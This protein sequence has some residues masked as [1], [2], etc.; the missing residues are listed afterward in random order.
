MNEYLL[1]ILIFL[2]GIATGFINTLAGSGSLISLPLLMFA[3]LPAPIANGTNR[4]GIVIQGIT[5][6]FTLRKKFPI[7]IRADIVIITSA[8][9]GAVCGAFLA[10]G[11]SKETLEMVIG[12]L[13][14]VMMMLMLVKPER[15]MKSENEQDRKKSNIAIQIIVFLLIGFYGGFIQAGV[16][17]F[18]LGG[19]VWVGGYN[20]MK[21]NSL[22][23]LITTIYTVIALPVFIYHDQI[24]W[25]N[26]LILAA[27]ASIGAFAGAKLAIKKGIGFVRIFL[28][29]IIFLAA[30]KL[31]NVDKLFIN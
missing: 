18:L 10:V 17:F 15:W 25:I 28:L 6:L 22:K 8:S 29:V 2:A 21:A 27:G 1:P 3:G 5:A 20:L 7:H 19:L 12:G 14:L 4:I 31:L 11:I 30:L 16:G 13:L 9:I 26:G 24:D 23:I